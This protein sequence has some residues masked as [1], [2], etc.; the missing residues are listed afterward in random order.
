MNPCVGAKERREKSNAR[1]RTH[2]SS[3]LDCFSR[4]PLFPLLQLISQRRPCCLPRIGLDL[5]G[6]STS[7][8][9]SSLP[10]LALHCLRVAESSPA[11]NLIEPFFDYLVGVETD[12]SSRT[13]LSGLNPNEL[14]WILEENEGR[15]IVLRVYNAKSQ[16]IRGEFCPAHEKSL[17][18]FSDLRGGVLV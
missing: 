11:S 8:L 4:G 3:L 5:M 1:A 2:A 7:S 10:D 12:P 6:Q 14:G 15:H 16:R 13:T 18:R 17:R 9:S